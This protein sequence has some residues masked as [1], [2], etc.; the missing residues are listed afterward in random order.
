M[1]SLINYLIQALVIYIFFVLGKLLGLKYGRQFFSQIFLKIAPFFKSERIIH[2]NLTTFK[3]DITEIEKKEIISCM[4]SNYGKTFLEYMFLK[5][6]RENNHFIKI[7]GENILKRVKERK[8]PVIFISG[9][10]ANFE[11][12]SMQITKKEIPLAAIYRPLNNYFLNP[13]MEYLRRKYVCKNQIKKGT[14]GVREAVQYIK[15]GFSIALM[16]DQRVSEGEKIE[17]FG[18]PAFT[19][20]LPAQ[21]S[22]KYGLSIVPVFI[23]RD[24][25]NFKIRF[26]DEIKSSDFKDK[27]LLTKKLSKILELMITRNPN[28]WIWTHNRWK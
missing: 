21:L 5:T 6:F 16:I 14:L 28:E 17:F 11:L 3:K 4:W 12:M 9:H 20:T 15:K 1:I 7:E 26:Y 10:F 23:E 27:L 18:K 13:L 24:K 8:K 2:K 22:I 25:E 19:T